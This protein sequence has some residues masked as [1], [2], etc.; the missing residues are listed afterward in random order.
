MSN[1]IGLVIATYQ[2]NEL[3]FKSLE[4]IIFGNLVPDV[5]VVVDNNVQQSISDEIKVFC[6]NKEK[7]KIISGHG[8]VGASQAFSL[9]MNLIYKDVDFLWVLDDD[10]IPECDCLSILHGECSRAEIAA[11]P[12]REYLDGQRHDFIQMINFSTGSKTRFKNHESDVFINVGCFEGLFFPSKFLSQI[13]VDYEKYF[14]GE[15][16]TIFGVNLSLICPIKYVSRAKMI[17]QIRPKRSTAPWKA[18]YV[19]RN[20]FYL[21]TDLRMI[22]EQKSF[23]TFGLVCLIGLRKVLTLTIRNPKSSMQSLRGMKDG[24]KYFFERSK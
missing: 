2:R 1:K 22:T 3:L 18:Y 6:K 16:D 8:N 10:V 13:K 20:H 7:I 15:D 24:I 21:Y 14:I 12:S 19:I 9:G 11:I 17:R 23:F 4:N 5:I